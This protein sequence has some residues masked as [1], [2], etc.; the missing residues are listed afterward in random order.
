MKHRTKIIYFLCFAIVLFFSCSLQ[1]AIAESSRLIPGLFDN[2]IQEGPEAKQP[3][4]AAPSRPAGLNQSQAEVGNS[5]NSQKTAVNGFFQEKGA[6]LKDLSSRGLN[7][8]KNK[9]LALANVKPWLQERREA[10]KLG[11]EEEKRELKE[12]F[13]NGAKSF[14]KNIFESFINIFK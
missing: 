3:S 11:V 5:T 14:F 1:T 9:V 8:L 7:L 2:P 13:K 12:D 6:Y 10:V 4:L